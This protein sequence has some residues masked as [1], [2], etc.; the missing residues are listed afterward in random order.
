MDQIPFRSVGLGE[1]TTYQ[2]VLAAI[3]IALF[4]TWAVGAFLGSQKLERASLIGL[5]L[6]GTGAALAWVFLG[7]PVF[8]AGI[9][10]A[11][12][13]RLGLSW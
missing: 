12:A 4:A 13:Q 5:A 10:R 3:L 7:V 11:V 8:P 9:L 1:C 2:I 6:L